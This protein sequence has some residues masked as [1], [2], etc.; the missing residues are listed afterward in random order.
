M[1]NN[2]TTRWAVKVDNVYI[3]EAI[4]RVAFSFGYY[5]SSGP[6]VSYTDA[7]YLVFDAKTKLITFTYTIDTVKETISK[8]VNSL[9]NVIDMFKNPP[10]EKLEFR[11]EILVSRNGDVTF[12]L[13]LIMNNNTFDDLVNDRNKFIGKTEKV[14]KSKVLPFVSFI[15]KSMNK[16][17]NTQMAR[18]L[19]VTEYDG[20]YIRGFDLD[21]GDAY[22][23]FMVKKIVGELKFEGFGSLKSVD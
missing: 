2:K 19:L 20:E 21:D 8:I 10:Q 23:T 22:K 6:V 18:K 5:W 7:N 17:K 13:P 1:N 3:S 12:T 15:Y 14:E 9:D 4:Q 11:P 16:Q